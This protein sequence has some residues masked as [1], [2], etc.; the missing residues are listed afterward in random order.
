MI[1]VCEVCGQTEEQQEQLEQS[2]S[3]EYHL[4][5]CPSCIEDRQ[6]IE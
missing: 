3:T 6:W 5:V 2:A 4:Y 1:R